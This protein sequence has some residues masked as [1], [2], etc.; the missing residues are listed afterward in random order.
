MVTDV[1][2]SKSRIYCLVGDSQQ[3]FVIFQGIKNVP[4]PNRTI[5][6]YVFWE[7]WPIKFF[8]LVP[9]HKVNK[10]SNKSCVCSESSV[11]KACH[12]RKC[13]VYSSK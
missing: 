7:I 3:I 2:Y 6:F 8:R 4:L 12:W 5:I 11:Y 10:E 13:G 1:M 9:V